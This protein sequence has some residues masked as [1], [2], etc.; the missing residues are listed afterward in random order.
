MVPTLDLEKS[1][2]M[3]ARFH[4]LFV[5]LISLLCRRREHGENKICDPVVFSQELDFIVRNL[6]LEVTF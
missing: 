4:G 3:L 5:V 2:K 6:L 1:C